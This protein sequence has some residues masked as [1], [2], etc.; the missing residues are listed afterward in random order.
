VSW[1]APAIG[2]II[3]TFAPLLARTGGVVILWLD[4]ASERWE[5]IIVEE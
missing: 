3:S 5:A 2:E 1:Q 4:H